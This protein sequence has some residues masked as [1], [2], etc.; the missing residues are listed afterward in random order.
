MIKLTIIILSCILFTN[1]DFNKEKTCYLTGKVIDRNS[2]ILIL[3][4]QTE[5]SRNR[6]IEIQ[7]DSNGI[8]NYELSLA[9]MEAYELIF[10]DELER[11]SWR[12]ILF[13]PENDT[14][15]F[16]LYSMQMADSNKIVGSKLSLKENLLN[17]KIKEKYYDQFSFW[18]QKKD[19]LEALN[20]TNSDYAKVV[21]DRIDSIYEEVALFELQYT[22]NEANLHGYCKFIRILRT[23]KDRKLFPI[24]TLNKYHNLFLQKFPNHPYNLISQYRIDGLK[25]IKVGGNYVDFT[26]PDS[27]GEKITLSDYILKNKFT[28]IDLWAPWCGPSIQKS[29]KAVPIFEEFKDSGFGVIGVVGSISSKEQFIQAIEKHKYPWTI[30]S[31]ISDKNNIWEKYSISKSGGSQFLVDNKGIIL[32]I[33]PTPD[34][35]RNMILNE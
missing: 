30:L 31:E 5:D 6:D 1:C 32:A 25:N 23:E 12:P 21:S 20:E 34:E 2:R 15:K 16:T 9:F 13:F 27:I 33:N 19:S 24:D 10:K 22:E 8:F 28:L 35:L 4:K 11:G 29:K 14:I 7:I 3:K 18:Y 17:Q 26:A